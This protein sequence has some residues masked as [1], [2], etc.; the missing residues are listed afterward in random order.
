[1]F[2]AYEF[3]TEKLTLHKFYQMKIYSNGLVP[4]VT[5]TTIHPNEPFCKIKINLYSATNNHRNYNLFMLSN[6][7]RITDV[8][9]AG[10]NG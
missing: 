9:F 3:L 5:R 4:L 1:M 7:L 6:I 10:R 8:F 2:H